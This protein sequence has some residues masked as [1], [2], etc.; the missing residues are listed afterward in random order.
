MTALGSESD[1]LERSRERHTLGRFGSDL[2]TLRI[3][4]PTRVSMRHQKKTALRGLA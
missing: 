1:G 4:R 3:S 2:L